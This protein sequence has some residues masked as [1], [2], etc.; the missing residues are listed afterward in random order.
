M[1]SNPFSS[2]LT[3]YAAV[4][5]YLGMIEA[6]RLLAQA[7]GNLLHAMAEGAGLGLVLLMIKLPQWW[8]RRNPP[9]R[10]E[11]DPE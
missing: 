10:R 4:C 1:L 7:A 9:A 11:H 6:K 5:P 3:Q 8:R 2:P